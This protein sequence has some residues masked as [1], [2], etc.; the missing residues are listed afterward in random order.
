[1]SCLINSEQLIIKQGELL[2]NSEHICDVFIESNSSKTQ[3]I[4]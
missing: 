2:Q 3:N 4:T 1:M